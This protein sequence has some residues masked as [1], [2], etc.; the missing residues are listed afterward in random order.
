MCPVGGGT[1]LE[2]AEV[3]ARLRRNGSRLPGTVRAIDWIP[4]GNGSQNEVAACSLGK[5]GQ[6][7][8]ETTVNE[9]LSGYRQTRMKIAIR[10]GQ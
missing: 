4:K 3:N 5:T 10:E 1:T 2:E 8:S 9:P 7:E 6:G